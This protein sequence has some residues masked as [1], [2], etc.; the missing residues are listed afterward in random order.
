MEAGATKRDTTVAER[1]AADQISRAGRT[2]SSTSARSSPKLIADVG[3]KQVFE[4]RSIM[5]RREHTSWLELDCG[6][7][8]E[9]SLKYTVSLLGR[10][11]KDQALCQLFPRN[12]IKRR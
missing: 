7:G 11:A 5:P 6:K 8:V 4:L 3:A 9:A 1:E 12:N 10:K 2:R